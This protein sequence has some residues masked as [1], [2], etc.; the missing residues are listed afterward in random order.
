MKM[1]SLRTGKRRDATLFF[2]VLLRVVVVKQ[3][4]ARV[5]R[6]LL[7]SSVFRVLYEFLWGDNWAGRMSF[8]R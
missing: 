6:S 7:Y 8:L 1:E 3:T 2:D 4:T 5:F